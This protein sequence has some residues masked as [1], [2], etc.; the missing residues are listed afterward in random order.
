VS[1]YDGA[2][3]LARVRAHWASRRTVPTGCWVCDV[4]LSACR[5]PWQGALRDERR[6]CA[7]RS[8]GIVDAH[9]CLPRRLIKQKARE[10]HPLGE[11]AGWVTE[12]LSDP[13]NGIVVRRLHHDQLESG[14]LAIPKVLWPEEALAFARELDLEYW[15]D[16]R[17]AKRA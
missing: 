14:H 2:E 11:D 1:G 7:E 8:G 9:H 15:I 16:N 6:M 10:R 4:L 3:F 12:A 5:E 13:R 17:E